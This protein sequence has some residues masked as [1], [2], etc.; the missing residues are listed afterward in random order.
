MV[1][2]HIVDLS[3][4]RDENL[5]ARI[6]N[7]DLKACEQCIPGNF[8]VKRSVSVLFLCTDTVHTL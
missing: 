4:S 6:L 7:F 5:L 1:D 2:L 3:L 8:S